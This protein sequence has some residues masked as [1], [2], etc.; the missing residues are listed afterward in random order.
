[1]AAGSNKG[2]PG[3]SLPRLSSLRLATV[4]EAGFPVRGQRGGGGDPA[5][6][7]VLQP[8]RRGGVRSG[9][10]MGTGR[11]CSWSWAGGR[12]LLRRRRRRSPDAG[13]S[14]TWFEGVGGRCRCSPST[15][16]TG[17]AGAAVREARVSS[18]AGMPQR[19]GPR[20][21][22][23]G[24]QQ[25]LKSRFAARKLFR[26]FWALWSFVLFSVGVSGDGSCRWRAVLVVLHFGPPVLCLFFGDLSAMCAGQLCVWF[27]PASSACMLRLLSE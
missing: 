1:M 13:C 9:A 2:A 23:R 4:L 8:C 17:F 11:R 7:F 15:V 21:S 6:H 22:R 27:L 26:I 18:P 19:Y 12:R 10:A 24:A 3:R 5:A 25:V 14:S 16:S 20:R